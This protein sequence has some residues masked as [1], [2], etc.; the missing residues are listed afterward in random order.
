ME[1]LGYTRVSSQEQGS[2][3][4]G[5]EVQRQA[6]EQ[7]CKTAG[8][9]LTLI[10]EVASAATISRRPALQQ[11]LESLAAGEA[12]ALVVAKL[13][14]LSRSLLD[15]AAIVEQSRKHGWKLIVLDLGVDTSSPSGEMLASV[16]A[17]FAQFERR[18]I[19]ERTKTAL[20]VKRSQG[21]RLGRPTSIDAET[22]AL[23]LRLR[24]EGQTLWGICH[25]LQRQGVPTAHGGKAWR[26]SSLKAVLTAC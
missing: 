6:I 2:S 1:V 14:R 15:F 9:H 13:D 22:R 18:L 12:D 11:A 25:E 23:I 3:R 10:E 7:R 20:A 17:T 24:S 4:A 21:V 5:L 8:W 19:S 26:P 16:L